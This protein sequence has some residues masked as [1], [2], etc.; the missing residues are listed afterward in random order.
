MANAASSTS[1]VPD[2]RVQRKQAIIVVAARLFARNGYA[3]CEMEQVASASKIAK[4]TL[5]LY[6]KSKE[7]LF[8]ACVD[9]GMQSLQVE[10]QAA[11]EQHA[12]PFARI[13][14]AILAYLLFFEEHPEQVELLMQERA[15][16]RDR[17]Q[18]TYFTHREAN[19]ERWR[20]VWSKLLRDG[21]IRSTLTVDQA[22]DF[23]GNL[24][25]GTMF[26]NHFLGRSASEQ[27]RTIMDILFR[28]VWS[29]STRRQSPPT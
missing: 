6:F 3:E 10:V 28:G 5:Y 9:H 13:S 7:E 11:A 19:R 29:D 2:H 12:E 4:G 15:F 26:T 22:L 20:E 23:V 24:V 16:F 27:H 25:Y 21:L 8:Y 14:A 18:P 17:K 1:G